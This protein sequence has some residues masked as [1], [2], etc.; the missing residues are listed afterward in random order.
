MALT[1]GDEVLA[2][3]MDDGYFY[4]AT[5]VGLDGAN[6]H[7]AYFDGAESDVPLRTLRRGVIGVKAQ[8]SVNWRG[9]GGYYGAVIQKRI[10]AAVYLNYEDGTSG[11]A[12]LA[13][14]RILG[15]VLSGIDVSLAACSYCGSAMYADALQCSTCGAPRSGRG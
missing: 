6:A 8:V 9:K 15:T 1:V 3:W 10:G 14:V 11:W 13:Q 2:P 12:T 7:I 5:I 4:P